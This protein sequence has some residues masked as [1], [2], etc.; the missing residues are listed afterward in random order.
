MRF[1]TKL[2]DSVIHCVRNKTYTNLSKHLSV[3]IYRHIR[4]REYG[5]I[6]AKVYEPAFTNTSRPI[7]RGIEA[8]LKSYFLNNE[9]SWQSRD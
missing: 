4:V 2:Y 9:P 1:Y 8:K 3:V 6:V 7:E 5:K